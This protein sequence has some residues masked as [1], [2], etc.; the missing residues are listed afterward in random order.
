MNKVKD[1]M[2]QLQ[3]ENA[4]LKEKIEDIIK[5]NPEML[6][7][8]DRTGFKLGMQEANN[9]TEKQN[10]EKERAV[11]EE[12]LKDWKNLLAS[13]KDDLLKKKQELSQTAEELKKTHETLNA[14]KQ[15]L[16]EELDKKKVEEDNK[17]NDEVAKQ[18][19]VSNKTLEEL[20]S[21]IKISKNG[22]FLTFPTLRAIFDGLALYVSQTFCQLIDDYRTER[23]EKRY[24]N[25]EFV[26]SFL[27]F[28]EKTKT[29]M[30]NKQQEFMDKLKV[31]SD[32]FAKSIQYHANQGNR[33]VLQLYPMLV[34]KLRS[35]KESDR[36]LK[37]E[38]V[39]DILKLKEK[40]L[41]ENKDELVDL[42]KESAQVK[43]LPE[44]IF[45]IMQFRL[46]D[47]ISKELKIEEEDITKAMKSLDFIVDP[48][49]QE[50]ALKVQ[51][52]NQ[53]VMASLLSKPVE[54][55]QK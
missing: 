54:V 34:A 20:A 45:S 42:M 7:N 19:K 51:Q 31:A 10:L 50:Q 30:A 37:K 4:K 39:L 46:S 12:E 44:Q 35:F 32:V 2:K 29:L 47:D 55:E 48:E 52:A 13:N 14:E 5:R 1:R 38:E 18:K 15:K 21:S 24:T 43:L 17:Y 49:V 36:V 53:N 8:F 41:L 26:E 9:Y 6:R 11:K 3:T 40:L 33:E 16:Y 22:D 25:K 23:R 27:A 28:E